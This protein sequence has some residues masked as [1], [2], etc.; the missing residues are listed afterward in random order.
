MNYIIVQALGKR[1]RTFELP[2][3]SS[4]NPTVSITWD[5]NINIH[6]ISYKSFFSVFT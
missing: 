4:P 6:F 5:I 1:L 3:H 2:T